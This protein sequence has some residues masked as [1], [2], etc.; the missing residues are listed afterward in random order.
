MVYLVY[1]C[2]YIYPVYESI[3]I[4]GTFLFKPQ[5]SGARNFFTG[6]LPV[7]WIIVCW[8]KSWLT[9]QCI[10]Q[11]GHACCEPSRLV[12]RD[13]L[14]PRVLTTQKSSRTLGV[15]RALGRVG[16]KKS[17][18]VNRQWDQRST[19]KWESVGITVEFHG[20]QPVFIQFSHRK[21][22]QVM[23]YGKYGP[24]PQVPLLSITSFDD[25]LVF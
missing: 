4:A 14:K 20:I 2:I 5:F 15:L 1:I 7:A 18:F 25:C 17:L 21:L 13:H 22:R 10:D 23:R 19:W 6:M 24:Q 11:A 3:Q 9:I 8:L 12:G 16:F